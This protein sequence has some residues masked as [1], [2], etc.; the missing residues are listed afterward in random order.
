MSQRIIDSLTRSR[1]LN[2]SGS[3]ESSRDL[4]Q[5]KTTKRRVPDVAVGISLILIGTLGSFLLYRSASQTVPVVGVAR[6]LDRGH[7]ITAND[8]QAVYVSP[9][10]S[11]LFVLG[12]EANSLIGQSLGVSVVE[13][14]PLTQSMLVDSQPLLND[15]ALTAASVDIG[16]IPANLSVNDVVRLVLTPDATIT[17]A[18]P[19]VMFDEPVSIWAIERSD[20]LS[21]SLVVTFRGPLRLSLAIASAGNIRISLVNS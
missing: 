6:S 9:E 2:N 10:S 15:E 8:L 3:V 18:S 5:G 16:N 19:P 4:A 12:S 17:N 7:V 1:V 13:S 11:K 21:N 14:T 20:E